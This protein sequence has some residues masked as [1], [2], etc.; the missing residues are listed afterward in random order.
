MYDSDSTAACVYGD[1]DGDLQEEM[2]RYLA[3]VGNLRKLIGGDV[4]RFRDEESVRMPLGL[5]ENA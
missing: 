2:R 1:D 5:R 3:D 4:A